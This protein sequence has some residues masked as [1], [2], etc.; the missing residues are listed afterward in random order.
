MAVHPVS[1]VIGSVL[2]LVVAGLAAPAPASADL[3]NCY[4]YDGLQPHQGGAEHDVSSS[5][6][7]VYGLITLR[8][9]DLCNTPQK[10]PFGSWDTASTVY[11]MVTNYG[12]QGAYGRWY[13]VGH[14]RQKGNG[15]AYHYMQYN[16]GDGSP[17]VTD[18]GPCATPNGTKYRYYIQK[19]SDDLGFFWDSRVLYDSN[20]ALAY[21]FNGDPSSLAWTTEDGEYSSEVI[22]EHDQ[23]GGGNLTRAKLENAGYYN[24]SLTLVNADIPA[25]DR[26][27][28]LCNP[29]TNGFPVGPYNTN[30]TNTRSF[31][32]WTD[33]F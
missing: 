17:I 9:P 28:Q 12:N 25:T 8:F 33:G 23:S 20:G 15:C 31:E 11:V 7:G 26:F 13:Q 2:L 1:R 22:N 24:S 6:R 16:P 4:P 10:D 30:W 21:A 29:S 32:I 3:G 18:L 27:C 5:S 19:L 14:V